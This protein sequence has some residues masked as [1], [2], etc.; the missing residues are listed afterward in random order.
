MYCKI[1][2]GTVKRRMKEKEREIEGIPQYTLIKG[3]YLIGAL[4]GKGACSRVYKAYDTVLETETAVK[5][6]VPFSGDTEGDRKSV[7]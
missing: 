4:L 3:R 1:L 7:V 6:F 2:L 5:E